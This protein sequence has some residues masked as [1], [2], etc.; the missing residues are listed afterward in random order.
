[1]RAKELRAIRAKLG[2]TQRELAE[3]VGIAPNNLA[4]QER[5][6]LGIRESQA[7]LIRF[8]AEQHETFDS[9]PSRRAAALKPPKGSRA[10]HSKG[11]SR[12][13]TRKNPVQ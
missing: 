11:K 1:M 7:R 4:K 5:G 10:R 9:Q 8:I 13:R 3:K 12:A 6:E 2:L